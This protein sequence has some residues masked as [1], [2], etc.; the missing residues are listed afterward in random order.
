MKKETKQSYDVIEIKL[1]YNASE[2]LKQAIG[3]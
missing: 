3:F 1:P 2:R